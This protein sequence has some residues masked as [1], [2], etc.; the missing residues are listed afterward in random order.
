MSQEKV[1]IYKERK[2]N[3]QKL[4]KKQKN[5]RIF[6]RLVFSLLGL[7][8]LFWIGASVYEKVTKTSLIPAKITEVDAT[9]INDYMAELNEMTT[10]SNQ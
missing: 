10:D 3:R 6:E 4:E 7:M 9:A 2:N 1:N 8:L 5:K